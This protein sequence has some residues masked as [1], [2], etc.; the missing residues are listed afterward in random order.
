M[1]KKLKEMEVD[2]NK[3]KF[4]K[5]YIENIAAANK[6][7]QTIPQKK[8]DVIVL[9]GW[10]IFCCMKTCCLLSLLLVSS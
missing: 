3:V 1:V 5:G 9:N 8:V 7:S 10:A 4:L 6:E 2:F